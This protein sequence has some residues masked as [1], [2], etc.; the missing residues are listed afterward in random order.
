M[1]QKLFISLLFISFC[2]QSIAQDDGWNN[3]IINGTDYNSTE[4]ARVSVRFTEG[5]STK[6]SD[7][8]L[9]SYIDENI[10]NGGYTGFDNNSL[11][12]I[13]CYPNPTSD[14]F[15]IETSSEKQ[16]CIMIFNL[17][18]QLV[19]SEEFTGKTSLNISKL[20]SG[21]YLYE[22]QF[23]NEKSIDGKLLKN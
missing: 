11:I 16:G 10:P 12:E 9:H 5:F 17:A 4:I 18:G 20:P 2:M 3:R 23:Q 8:Y 6:T 19:I 22:I 15:Y 7:K 1:K 14:Y 21:L 13:S